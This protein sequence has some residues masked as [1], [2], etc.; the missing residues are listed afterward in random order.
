MATAAPSTPAFDDP[1]PVVSHDGIVQLSW[2]GPPGDYE[3]RLD[4]R[5]FYRGRLPSAHL[6]GLREGDYT[7]SIRARD[8]GGWSPWSPAK[9]ITVRHHSLPL[10]FSLMALG[11]LT[12]GGTAVVVL[13]SSRRSA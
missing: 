10:V 5:V 4:E 12:F 2:S 6:S 7:V 3:V 11:L 1:E 9:H 13:R 8:D